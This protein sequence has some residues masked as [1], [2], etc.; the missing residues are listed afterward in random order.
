MIILHIARLY[1]IPK[2]ELRTKTKLKNLESLNTKRLIFLLSTG[3]FQQKSS[4]L[5]R[6]S[7]VPHQGS[8]LITRITERKERREENRRKGGE[9]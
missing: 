8:G 2:I 5:S 6:I 3:K 7:T 4:N 9:G 1:Q